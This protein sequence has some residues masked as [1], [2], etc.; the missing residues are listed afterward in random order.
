MIDVNINGLLH[1]IAEALSRKIKQKSG[2]IID[3]TSVA[4][5]KVS[6]GGTV[7]AATKHV[8]R[9]ISEGLRQEVKPYN[10]C[11]TI[12]SPVAVATELTQSITD[13]DIA[14]GMIL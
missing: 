2:H 3:V 8:A 11:T 9:V 5:H 12:I 7:Y 14:Q 1:G 4:G 13:P 6:P 10:I